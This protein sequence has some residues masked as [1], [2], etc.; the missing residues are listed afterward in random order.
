M[1]GDLDLWPFQLKI[2]SLHT[3]TLE[4]VYTNYP[5][6][7]SQKATLV[8]V[9]LVVVVISSLPKALLICSGA[10]HTLR[11]HSSWH[12]SQINRLRFLADITLQCH[13]CDQSSFHVVDLKLRAI[14]KPVGLKVC[15]CLGLT[16]ANCYVW[17][18][19]WFATLLL[20]GW[21]VRP[22]VVC[23]TRAPR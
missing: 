4:N 2:G 12:S 21:S 20:G 16:A 9:V 15:L 5:E 13:Y 10:Q 1:S 7:G 22:Y 3:R 11:T 23:N 14:I 6:G 17:G 19:T 8:V 18:K